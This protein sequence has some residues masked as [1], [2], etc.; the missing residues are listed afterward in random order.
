[1]RY[2]PKPLQLVVGLLV[3]LGL[4]C[5]PCGSL[6]GSMPT[7]PHKVVLSTDSAARLDSRLRQS[8][9]GAPGQRFILSMTDSEVTSLVAS[10]LAAYGK[11][12]AVQNPVIWFSGGRIY[13]TGRLVH[14]LPVESDF[15]LVA[16]AIARD[17]KLIIEM[18]QISTGS[19]TIPDGVRGMLSQS[20]SETI[21]DLQLGVT[22][23]GLEIREGEA[24]VR[25]RCQ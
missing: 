13:A 10:E 15:F 14:V 17:G 22:I 2:P 18:E 20:V 25:G 5:G 8:L 21:D 19:L 12:S 6:A 7:P 9:Q 3:M 16:K 4:A 24:I 11:A 1:M 23:T